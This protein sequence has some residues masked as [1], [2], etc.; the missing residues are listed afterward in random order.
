M[1]A[2][3]VPDGEPVIAVVEMGGEILELIHGEVPFGN[4]LTVATEAVIF[5]QRED[6]LV[7]NRGRIRRGGGGEEAGQDSA[8][9][10][11]FQRENAAGKG[12]HRGK[13]DFGLVHRVAFPQ[14]F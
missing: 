2:D 1:T 5:Q 3:V 6:F 14:P 11:I 8:A 10:E 12:V 4:A 7:V 9:G 13:C